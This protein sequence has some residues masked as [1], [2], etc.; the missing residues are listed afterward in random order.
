MKK[1]LYL[2]VVSLFIALASSCVDQPTDVGKPDKAKIV[3]TVGQW[4]STTA[5]ESTSVEKINL[6]V[7]YP[8]GKTLKASNDY[9]LTDVV[10]KYSH[11]S[12]LSIDV[13]VRYAND[14]EGPPAEDPVEISK[15][16]F[17]VIL[18]NWSA[19]LFALM[20]FIKVI[21]NLTPSKKDNDV[22]GWIDTIFNAVVPN[23]K[24]G[25]GKHAPQR[26]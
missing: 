24:S 23:Y 14:V 12:V 13:P 6:Q 18:E 17:D 3:Q 5:V 21:V 4:G 26:E 7:D 9:E 16:F 11:A 1:F 8:L 10:S 19:V 15:G 2:L 25:G 20:G 22:F